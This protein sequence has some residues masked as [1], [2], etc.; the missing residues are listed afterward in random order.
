MRRTLFRKKF[1][2]RSLQRW[3]VCID[4]AIVEFEFKLH[5][6]KMRQPAQCFIRLK[7]SKF[8]G[9]L[10]LR[11]GVG[12][13]PVCDGPG[14]DSLLKLTWHDDAAGFQGRPEMS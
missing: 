14:A 7:S 10:F 1:N 12:D 9:V 8:F 4:F 11:A 5:S 6:P 13:K 3:N 2:K